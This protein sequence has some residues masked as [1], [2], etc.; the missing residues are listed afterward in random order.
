MSSYCLSF[1]HDV[2]SC[3]YYDIYVE[4]YA[5]LDKM[6]E[7]MIEQLAQLV[8]EVKEHDFL[9]EIDLSLTSPTLELVPSIPFPLIT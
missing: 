9:H 3:S 1:R 8:N 4:C 7:T 2:N 6:I 5:R